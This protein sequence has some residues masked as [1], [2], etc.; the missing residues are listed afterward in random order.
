MGARGGRRH[1]CPRRRWQWRRRG[2]AGRV[3]K[4]K[5]FSD[6]R[7]FAK[8]KNFLEDWACDFKVVLS[9]QSPEMKKTPEDVEKYQGDLDVGTVISLNPDRRS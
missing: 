4:D 1:A 9:T 5:A 2:A 6:V 3:I 7:K 8:V